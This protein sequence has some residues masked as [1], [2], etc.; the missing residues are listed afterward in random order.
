[1][2]FTGVLGTANS[3][4]G[5]LVLASYGASSSVVIGGW[6]RVVVI[7]ASRSRIEAKEIKVKD[8]K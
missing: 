3:T 7:F 2:S 4:L 6:R 5:N 8:D 1:M